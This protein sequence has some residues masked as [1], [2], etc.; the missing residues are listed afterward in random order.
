[1]TPRGPIG[2]L[3][4]H[5]K[6]ASL[7]GFD[8]CALR[9]PRSRPGAPGNTASRLVIVGLSIFALL[10]LVSAPVAVL[11]SNQLDRFVALKLIGVGSERATLVRAETYFNDLS[12]LFFAVRAVSDV[13]MLI[14][15]VAGLVW[16]YQVWNGTR[17]R[18]KGSQESPR[19]VVLWSLVP[20]WGLLRL[21]EFLLRIARATACPPETLNLGAWVCA[22]VLHVCLRVAAARQIGGIAVVDSIVAVCAALL[23]IRIVQRLQRSLVNEQV[24]PSLGQGASKTPS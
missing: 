9:S 20:L 18:R 2:T 7:G 4:T 3:S 19:G 1:M 8:R 23:G 10:Q 21:H 5:G 15:Y 24:A 13:G 14:G 6:G 12:A 17:S 16:L 22:M 11:A